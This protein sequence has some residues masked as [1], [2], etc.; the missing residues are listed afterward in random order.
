MVGPSKPYRSFINL[1]L[2]LAKWQDALPGLW[3]QAS[4]ET[5]DLSLV[6]VIHVVEGEKT[7]SCKF[8]DSHI[9]VVTL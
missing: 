9:Y 5:G 8:S 1:V 3:K 2:G 6:T 4:Y 7:D